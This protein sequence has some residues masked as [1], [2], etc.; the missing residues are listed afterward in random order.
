MKQRKV[1]K[2]LLLVIINIMIIAAVA[3]EEIIIFPHSVNKIPVLLNNKDYI[4]F[5]YGGWG[6]GWAF[7]TLKGKLSEDK[8]TMK[9]E[10]HA[11]IRKD[12]AKVSINASLKKTNSKT[13]EISTT[14]STDKDTNLQFFIQGIT[15]SN[16]FDK[17]KIIAKLA[18]G[19]T[20]EVKFPIG[21]Q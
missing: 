4:T 1:L 16:K 6:A 9:I 19:K 13:L 15:F 17:G 8:A 12:K 10:S 2:S 11:T 20:K 21:K 7:S 14:I 18:D 5:T 3:E